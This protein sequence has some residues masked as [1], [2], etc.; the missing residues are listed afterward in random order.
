MTTHAE[1]IETMDPQT[2]EMDG[3]QPF[4]YALT[5]QSP[6]W[7]VSAML[8]VLVIVLAGLVSLAIKPPTLEDEFIAVTTIGKSPELQQPERAP[9]STSVLNGDK[10]ADPTS[11]N[12]SVKSDVSV[13]PE[14]LKIAKIGDHDEMD[15]PWLE[16]KHTMP[17]SEDSHLIWQTR[18]LDSTPGGGGVGGATLAD[19]VGV[20]GDGSAGSD[21]G[22]GGG[23]GGGFGK[24]V[25]IGHEPFGHG[26]T[27]G[28]MNMVMNRGGSR[29]TENGVAKALRWLAYH[30]EADG[31]WDTM[32]FGSGQKT[33]TAI[34]G[35]ALL[36]F[37][38]AGNSE[39]SGEYRDN[40]KRAVGWLTSKQQASGLVFDPTDAGAH[41]GIGYPT[42][43]AS[44]ALAEAAAMSGKA[45]T[46]ATAQKA[47]N[48]ITEQHQ[49]GDGSEKLGWR[50]NPKQAGDTSVTGWMVMALKSAKLAGLHVDMAA[51]TGALTFLDSVQ[52]KDAGGDTGYGPVVHYGYQPGNEHASSTHRL[53]AI[54]NLI[55]MFLG[56]NPDS[57]NSSV[58]WFVNKGGVPTWGA[59]GEGVD[60]YYW[61]Y[62]SLCTFQTGGDVWDRWNKGMVK[63]LVDNQCANGDD[64]GSWP[65]VGEFSSEWGRVGQTALGCLSLEVYYRYD[66]LKR[67][68][69]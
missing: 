63:A 23:K 34:T 66:F 44:L 42:A 58:E 54:G 35:M 48:Y 5:G 19:V 60:M 64:A 1:A 26:R 21:G 49:C 13:D 46:K 55:K 32:K 4:L 50:Y 17:G 69:K 30:Q 38:G 3:K 27:G 31:R 56:V 28:R 7:V 61:Y 43:I 62:G 18:D 57:L 16:D 65:I 8:H 45:E 2:H 24:D 67:A 10:D 39:R 36:A 68:G 25:G 47:I 9:A 14:F 6:W 51:F 29:A 52:Y 59:N 41:R 20:G 37:L 11:P 33:D 53:S 22:W 40:V 12:S 15:T